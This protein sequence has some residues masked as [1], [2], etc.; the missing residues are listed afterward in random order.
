[1]VTGKFCPPEADPPRAGRLETGSWKPATR[2][3]SRNLKRAAG[4]IRAPW[5]RPES[6]CFGIWA[7]LGIKQR[8]LERTE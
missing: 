2:A 1:M 3:A 7:G 5:S 4:E 6:R 8:A